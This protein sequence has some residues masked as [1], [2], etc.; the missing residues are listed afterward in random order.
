MDKE[1]YFDSTDF[2]CNINDEY[3]L[4]KEA[5]LKSIGVTKEEIIARKH[6][7][8]EECL[9]DAFN[10]SNDIN[11]KKKFIVNFSLA[12]C[13][14]YRPSRNLLE[15]IVD[16]FEKMDKAALETLFAFEPEDND[17]HSHNSFHL[18]LIVDSSFETSERTFYDQTGYI[19]TNTGRFYSL[20]PY[21]KDNGY[22]DL[23]KRMIK[24]VGEVIK[25]IPND[26]IPMTIATINYAKLNDI[27]SYNYLLDIFNS[28][29]ID[30]NSIL[31]DCCGIE[32]GEVTEECWR[33]TIAETLD[34]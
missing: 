12:I 20:I 22:D 4:E 29:N 5:F 17:N 27:D 9:K 10:F 7:Y 14:A 13:S 34:E 19:I 15:S 26:V 6:S 3:F 23:F 8:C 28:T 2:L 30:K 1:E 16:L 21:L 11:E 18:C 31:Y 24:V 33:K 25:L 32:T